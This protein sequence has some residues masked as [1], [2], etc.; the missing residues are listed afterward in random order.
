M[1]TKTQ[2]LPEQIVVR[3]YDPKR[4]VPMKIRPMQ[5]RTGRLW[6][7]QGVNGYYDTLSHEEKLKMS[8][9][10]TP[11]TAVVLTDGKVFK[12]SDPIDKANMAWVLRHPYVAK[13]FE[14]GKSSRDAV[15]YIEDKVAEAEKRVN[16][17]KTKDK[18]RYVVQY[19]LSLDKLRHVAKALGNLAAGSFTELEVKDWILNLCEVAPDSVLY[20]TDEKNAHETDAVIQFHEFTKWQIIQKFRGG[21]YRIGTEDG[22]YVGHTQEQVVEFLRKEENKET[23]AALEAELKAKKT[24]V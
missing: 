10:I 18:A 13:N 21:V 16:K 11:D 3:A 17:S 9:I 24:S 23:V 22:V 1:E 20:H 8:Y 12:S 7:G 2:Q 15:F 6:T 14:A 19:E 4:A 5:D